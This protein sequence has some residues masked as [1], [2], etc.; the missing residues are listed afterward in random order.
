MSALA[1]DAPRG[2]VPMRE[3]LRL[4]K[5]L[6]EA[7][8]EL[9]YLRSEASE[10]LHDELV[11]MLR[12]R[13]KLARTHILILREVCLAG[14]AG[15][16]METLR[17]RAGTPQLKTIDVHIWKINQ[18]LGAQGCPRVFALRALYGRR[19]LSPEGRAWLQERAPELFT[20]GAKP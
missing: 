19:V 1:D 6:D 17:D 16:P 2:F 7:E 12:C 4:Q 11:A 20:K 3:Y 10:E 14:E 5:R 8:D 9:A 15:V 13:L 18:S